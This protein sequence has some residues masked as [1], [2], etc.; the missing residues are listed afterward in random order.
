V[1]QGLAVAMVERQVWNFIR[2]FLVC[3][4]LTA[5]EPRVPLLPL[6]DLD[7][8]ENHSWLGMG[9]KKDTNVQLQLF[10]KKWFL[11]SWLPQSQCFHSH[12]M[13]AC[14]IMLC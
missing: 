8:N 11:Y 3:Y 12:W 14:A 9:V 5:L 7:I 4:C 13:L 1:I 10:A 6:A 2:L